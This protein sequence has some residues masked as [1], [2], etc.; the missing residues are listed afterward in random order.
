M[1]FWSHRSLVPLVRR[2]LP[3]GENKLQG[4]PNSSEGLEDDQAD[5]EDDDRVWEDG[6]V[7]TGLNSMPTFNERLD[8]D[9][10]LIGSF[11]DGL[12]YQRRFGDV[13]MLES[14]ERNG[15]GFFR[16]AGNCLD[17]ERRLNSSRASSPTMW[18]PA[19]ANTMYY[20]ACPRLADRDT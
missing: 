3:E 9:I 16:L 8:D 1:P 12:E 15:A 18:E 13:R 19:T 6:L 7:D 2:L 4:V 14:L 10:N 20:R 17:R 5:D 11:L